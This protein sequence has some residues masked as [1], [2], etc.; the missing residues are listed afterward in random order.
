MGADTSAA[1]TRAGA[2]VAGTRQDWRLGRRGRKAALVLHIVAAGA[3]LGIDVVLAVL[4]GT[5][6]GTGD[7]RTAGVAYQA[8]ALVLWPLLIAGVVCLVSGILLGLGTRYGLIRYWWVVVK[9]VINTLFVVLVVVALRPT[10]VEA[11]GAAGRGVVG[12]P[13][14]V[15]D[16]V[17]P[18]V[19]SLTGLLVATTLAVYK[20]WGRVRR[21][22]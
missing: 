6:L 14:P 13:V 9:L 11:A 20:P 21:R 8:L 3:W 10:V 5:A 4:V 16:V 19:V 2:H 22:G 18:P 1:P 12:I 7:P 15:T 17:A